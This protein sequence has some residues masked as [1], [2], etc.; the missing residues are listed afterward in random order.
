M[1]DH[2]S[3]CFL[4]DV[5]LMLHPC[6]VF[7]L[8]CLYFLTPLWSLSW[9]DLFALFAED[10]DIIKLI[11][12]SCIFLGKNSII[13]LKF[14]DEYWKLICLFFEFSC[15]IIKIFIFINVIIYFNL[16]SCIKMLKYLWLILERL[17]GLNEL[18]IGICFV[19]V[20]L[21]SEL[22]ELALNLNDILLLNADVK[23]E[24]IVLSLYILKSFFHPSF[25][26]HYFL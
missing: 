3:V 1:L 8:E 19:M 6:C 23:L 10:A 12:Q 22:I 11:A 16:D 4:L 20:R 21:W 2:R 25:F 14:L 17:V 26:A 7:L 24:E 9:V 18:L 5:A 13:V 15:Q